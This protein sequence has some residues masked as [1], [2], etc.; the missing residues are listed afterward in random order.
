MEMSREMEIDVIRRNQIL[1]IMN[2]HW[3]FQSSPIGFIL[4]F[5]LFRVC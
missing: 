4:F 1:K 5:S 3:Y 2:S